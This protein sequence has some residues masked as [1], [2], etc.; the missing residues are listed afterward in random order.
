VTK[1]AQ[2]IT[3]Y[4]IDGRVKQDENRRNIEKTFLCGFFKTLNFG[5]HFLKN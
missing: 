4:G 3:E 5:Y 1:G 2:A